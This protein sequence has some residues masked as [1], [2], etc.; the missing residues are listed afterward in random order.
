MLGPV[1]E[2]TKRFFQKCTNLKAAIALSKFN[3]AKK[4]DEIEKDTTAS[5]SSQVNEGFCCT[6]GLYEIKTE[7][8]IGIIFF[9]Y[10]EL[11]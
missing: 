9:S 7:R 2:Q 11:H 10:G 3:G 8:G 5:L 4:I 1:D 6:K